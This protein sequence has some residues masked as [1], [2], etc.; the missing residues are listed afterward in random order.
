MT[1]PAPGLRGALHRISE[2]RTHADWADFL[3]EQAAAQAD[4]Y[5]DLQFDPDLDDGPDEAAR[6]FA[7]RSLCYATQIIL[8]ALVL[9]FVGALAWRAM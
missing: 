8:V 5:D 6:D 4:D 7:A 1:R 9:I 3:A 2:D